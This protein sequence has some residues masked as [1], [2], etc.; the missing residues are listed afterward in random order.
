M[1]RQ[2]AVSVL[3]AYASV[4]P[5]AGRVTSATQQP[6]F[7]T[8]VDVIVVDVAVLDREG[9][10]VPEPPSSSFEVTID[11]RRRPVASAQF[12]RYLPA[13]SGTVRLPGTAPTMGGNVWPSDAPSRTFILAVDTAS[14]SAGE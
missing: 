5:G 9:R 10:P 12:M 13:S 14:F 6:A 4:A 2:A 1:F 8:A 11:G 7:R 3:A